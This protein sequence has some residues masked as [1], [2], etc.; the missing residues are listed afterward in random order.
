MITFIDEHRARRDPSAGVGIDIP[1]NEQIE[2]EIAVQLLDTPTN[3]TGLTFTNTA[4]YL[5]NRIN[6][7]NASQRPGLPGTTAAMTIVGPDT[8][9]LQKSGPARMTLGQPGVFAL[10]VQNT[11]T[12]RAWDLTILDRLPN[13]A[14]SGI[15][16]RFTWGR[17][18]LKP[19]PDQLLDR[20]RRL[21]PA[22]RWATA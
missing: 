14:T 18:W 21:T 7:I 5:F 22:L 2:I 3:V 1:A 4:N 6:N 12:G 11:G 13:T 10:N 20:T 17:T 16:S 9:T 15:W 19:P 8:V